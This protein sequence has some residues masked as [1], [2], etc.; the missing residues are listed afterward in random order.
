MSGGDPIVAIDQDRIC[1]AERF[2][3][4]GNLPNLVFCVG[5]GIVSIGVQ[6][7]YRLVSDYEGFWVQS[8]LPTTGLEQTRHASSL[9]CL[10]D[11]GSFGLK[12]LKCQG[13]GRQQKEDGKCNQMLGIAISY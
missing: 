4:F 6:G 5:S 8:Q 3:A 2:H 13:S 7:R 9:S 1:E 10:E 11:T 12:R